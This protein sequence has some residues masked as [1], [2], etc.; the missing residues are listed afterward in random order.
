MTDQTTG[1]PTDGGPA[2]GE[3]TNAE[4]LTALGAYAKA[5]KPMEEALRA[6]T[7]DD[8]RRNRA[9]RVGAYMPDGE[10]IG[11]VGYNPGNKKA[12]V[13]DSAA[14]LAWCLAKYPDAIVQAVNP[15]FL[16]NLTDY[17][18]KVGE[19]GEPGVDPRTGEVLDFITVERGAAFVTVTPTKEG[20]ARMAA[21]AGG[22]AGML[23]SPAAAPGP[24]AIGLYE[25]GLC[26]V[27]GATGW[28]ATHG[29]V[30]A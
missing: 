18:A 24:D 27:D 5:L 30:E 3:L 12:S 8:M 7:L 13:T 6:A 28:C 29:R 14:A 2:R 26:I 21:L 19:V 22:F 10:K 23:E 15:T 9:E 20:V 17:A 1:A 4:K 11:A 25:S 16:K